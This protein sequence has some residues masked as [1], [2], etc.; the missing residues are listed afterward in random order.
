MKK[1]YHDHYKTYKNEY[2]KLKI[3]GGN[4]SKN[5][6]YTFKYFPNVENQVKFISDNFD[7]IVSLLSTCFPANVKGEKELSEFNN[8]MKS[9]VD[10]YQN[11][12]QWYFALHNDVIV[13]CCLITPYTFVKTDETIETYKKVTLFEYELNDIIGDERDVNFCISSLCKDSNYANV[14]SFILNEL[15]KLYAKKIDTFLIPPIPEVKPDNKFYLV[16]GSDYHKNNYEHYINKKCIIDN[17]YY[18]SNMKL[19]EYYKKN[20]FKV[21]DNL[22]VVDKC[23]D[24]PDEYI[25]SNVMYKKFK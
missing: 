18:D 7:R 20:G 12:G 13:G 1:T 21:S 14:G 5:M 24:V 4:G 10:S 25:I 22:Y 6:Q 11:T 3:N 2:L 23:Y 19:M 9:I 16:V 17:E 8:K 15:D